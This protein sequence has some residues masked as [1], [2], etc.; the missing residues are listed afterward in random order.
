[1]WK[2]MSQLNTSPK[3]LIAHTSS[4]NADRPPS[5]LHNSTYDCKLG[6]NP[7]IVICKSLFI[8][9]PRQ[10]KTGYGSGVAM[11]EQSNRFIG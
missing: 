11:G 1:M 2:I 4:V 3:A 7:K 8:L 6:P 10:N 9:S 5:R